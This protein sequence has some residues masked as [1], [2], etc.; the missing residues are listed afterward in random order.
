MQNKILQIS[1]F[2]IYTNVLNKA[3][4]NKC[5]YIWLLYEHIDSKSIIPIVSTQPSTLL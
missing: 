5:D 3:E 2:Y 4:E 1:L